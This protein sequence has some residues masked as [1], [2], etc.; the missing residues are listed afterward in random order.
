M[1]S[2]KEKEVWKEAT[3]A[4]DRSFRPMKSNGGRRHAPFYKVLQG[5]PIAVDAFKYG[6][7]PGVTA[8]FLTHAHSDHYTNLS[9]K[10]KNGPIYCSEGTA[11]LIIHMLSVD[12]K[13]VHPLPMDTPIVVPNTNG[14]TV[15]LIEANHCPGSCL[16][17]FEGR[18]T[19]NAGDSAFKSSH[20]GSSKVFRY[21][22]CGDFRASPA[23]ILHP[24][25]KG[26]VID[27]VYLDTTYLDPKYT[28]PPQPLVISACADLAKRIVNGHLMQINS[29]TYS[30]GKERIAK[31]KSFIVSPPAKHHHEHLLIAVANALNTK[32]YCDARKMAILRCQADAEL[33]NLLTNNPE[34]GNVHLIPLSSI[35]TDQLKLY[36]EK[37]KQTYD[38]IIG[39]RP[40]GWTYTQPA[41]TNQSPSISSILS[42]SA[43][44]NYTFA[45]L[46]LSPRS[47]QS[48]Q[49]YPVPYSEH[50]SFHEL[51]CFAMSFNWTKM[52]ATVN[53][54]SEKSRAKMARWMAKWETERKKRG[55]DQVVPHR[56]PDYW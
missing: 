36:L 42:A 44:S 55:K 49:L 32:I 15:T 28:F 18:Q 40:T 46:Q 31:G 48:L 39:F 53:V 13:W 2:F 21:L 1:T 41:G 30:I 3:V 6:A 56:H 20:V 47:T 7:I 14:V 22:H 54:G 45:D 27:H 37:Y 35:S 26:K 5:M 51:T 11:N 19:V 43:S 52:I 4:D 24:V 9:S 12:R 38:R 23:H 33:H 34:E 16:F 25:V 10:W 29:R 8:Y 17:F 50:S